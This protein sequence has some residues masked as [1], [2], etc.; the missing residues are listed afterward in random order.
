MTTPGDSKIY[1]RKR[2]GF[3]KLALEHGIHLV[4]MVSPLCSSALSH[5]FPVYIRREWN[6][7]N[8]EVVYGFEYE[9]STTK[10]ITGVRVWLQDN[11][12]LGIPLAWGPYPL[13]PLIPYPVPLNLEVYRFQKMIWFTLDWCSNSSQNEAWRLNYSERYWWFA[14]QIHERNES[15]LWSNQTQ[16]LRVW[17]YWV[18]NFVILFETVVFL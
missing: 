18:E 17:K 8:L 7:Y 6:L 9:I 16:V 13:L 11:L 10:R 2:K 14:W 1:L 15:P 4:P 3:V 5:S 12:K